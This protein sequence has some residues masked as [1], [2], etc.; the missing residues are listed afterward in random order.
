M[1]IL[2]PKCPACIAA[3]IAAGTGVAL[4]AMVAGSIR[5]LLMIVCVFSVAVLVLRA[6]VWRVLISTP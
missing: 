5:P 1:A 6:R 3:W 2:L 4:P